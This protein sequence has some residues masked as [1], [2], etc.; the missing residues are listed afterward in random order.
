MLSN[1]MLNLVKDSEKRKVFS[2]IYRVLRRSGRAVISDIVSDEPV[3]AHLKNDPELWSGCVSGALQDA[4]FLR[5]FE[6]AGFS[7]SRS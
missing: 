7:E 2:E 5:A 1:C 4:E 6:E 3:A